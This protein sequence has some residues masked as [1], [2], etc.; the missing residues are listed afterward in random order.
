MQIDDKTFERILDETPIEELEDAWRISRFTASKRW[1]DY[2]QRLGNR[3]GFG[4]GVWA[5]MTIVT[6]LNGGCLLFDVGR[7]WVDV[8]APMMIGVIAFVGT[9]GSMRANQMY[10]YGGKA[11]RK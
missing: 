3:E 5:A 6:L 10:L 11:T 8:V 4:V 7:G 9:A 1:C 2:A